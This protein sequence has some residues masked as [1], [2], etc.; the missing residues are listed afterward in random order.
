MNVMTKETL[1]EEIT[2]NKLTDL[3]IAQKYNYSYITIGNMRRSLGLPCNK[4]KR[5]LF[6]KPSKEELSNLY[7]KF[8]SD[9]KVANY[10]GVYT[11]KIKELRVLYD[12]KVDNRIFP[13]VILT[14][15]QKE[16]LFG[17]LLGDGYCKK[18]KNQICPSFLIDHS[19]KQ[20]EYVD[21]IASY[22]NN[23]PNRKYE[24]I[25]G[26]NK[27]TNKRYNC[28]CLSFYEN[29]AF[30]FFRDNF[31]INNIKEIPIKLLEEFYTPKAMAFHYMDDGC[32]TRKNC[33][34]AMC[35]FKEEQINQL[36]AFLL[37]KYNIDTTITKRK[38]M[39]IKKNSVPKFFKLITPYICESMIY[40]LV[41]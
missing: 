16:I 11:S 8:G 6:I 40:K 23:L 19:I 32:Y 41:S 2:V 4:K 24:H 34:I 10:L 38:D 17:I 30:D 14:H 15:E 33:K 1:I 5:A 9:S 31:Y 12:L 20:K 3:E 39:Y 36:R 25:T 29:R 37:K 27:K 22:F 26:I 28:Y 7:K 35:G 21:Y 13:E 18:R